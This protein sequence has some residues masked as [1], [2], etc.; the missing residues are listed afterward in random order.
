M[1]RREAAFRFIL[2]LLVID[3]LGIGMIVPV[4]PHLVTHLAGGTESQAA[5]IFGRFIAVFAAMQFLFS[6]LLGA[7]SDRYGRRPVILVSTCGMAIDYL[8]MTVAPNLTWL[9]VGRVLSGISSAN[10][11]TSYAYIADITP[12]EERAQRYG[13]IGG[14]FGAGFVV[15]P[16]MGGF[17]GV[18]NPRAPFLAAAVLSMCSFLYG[19]FILPESHAPENRRRVSF[20]RA[21]PF[22]SLYALRLNP[23][24]ANLATTLMFVN[25]SAFLGHSIWVLYTA[26]R[27]KWSERDVGI[28]LAMVGVL[29]WAFQSGGT[30]YFSKRLGE[31]RALYLALICSAISGVLYG[32]ASQ[33]WMIYCILF[34]GCFGSMC[35]PIL[36]TLVTRQVPPTEQGV[37]Q[38][39]VAALN[40][41]AAFVS[42]LLGTYL[43]KVFTAPGAP[44]VPGISFFLGSF[45][46]VIAAL[47]AWR[48]RRQ[49]RDRAPDSVEVVEELPHTSADVEHPV[50]APG[51]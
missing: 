25:L 30:A 24:V 34:V 7:L 37:V 35:G 47:M 2:L 51:H 6:P 13:M 15:G 23:V 45:L 27:Y 42:P 5:P 50:A 16:A 26:Y 31:W 20:G 4:L 32:L 41:V 48:T 22:G 44:H 29:I 21:N 11:A 49:C 19:L 38:G 10:L 14:A 28:S 3:M 12:P 18:I 43:F 8:L 9:F 46:A 17:L 33:G 36:Q 40:S 1:Q 39:A